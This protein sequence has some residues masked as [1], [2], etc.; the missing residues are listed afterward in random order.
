MKMYI[1]VKDTVPNNMVPVIAAHASL[2]TYLKYQN[3][4]DCKR[5]LNTSFKK[6]VCK[7]TD[8]EFEE[9]KT[10]EANCV[11]TESSLNNNEVAISFCPRDNFP[12]IFG[13]YKL[14][15]IE[16]KLQK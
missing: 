4:N 11:T 3:D 1:L 8:S 2:A 12:S 16:C 5:W 9:A 13:R 7:I 14:W 15:S 10:V 6:V